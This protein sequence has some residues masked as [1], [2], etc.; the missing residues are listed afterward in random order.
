MNRISDLERQLRNLEDKKQTTSG[1]GQ[2]HLI[3]FGNHNIL[4]P[5]ESEF[6]DVDEYELFPD[7]DL[8]YTA[9]ASNPWWIEYADGFENYSELESLGKIQQ[10]NIPDALEALT[11][12]IAN[13]HIEDDNGQAYYVGPTSNMHMLRRPFI[14]P[15]PGP[16]RVR[17]VRSVFDSQSISGPTIPRPYLLDIYWS[18][19]EQYFPSFSESLW[20]DYRSGKSQ[21][22]SLD[23]MDDMICAVGYWHLKPGDRCFQ[24]REVGLEF[25]MQRFT[26]AVGQEV[27]HVCLSNVRTFL[28]RSY[29]AIMEGKTESATIFLGDETPIKQTLNIADFT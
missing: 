14:N 9:D 2:G 21:S 29:L 11:S 15:T 13:L 1:A 27:D 19:F 5:L 22:H 12:V 4:Q 3:P 24:F 16:S 8:G 25:H 10:N 18:Q 20:Q 28:L 7:F 17:P 23:F 6:L 26:S